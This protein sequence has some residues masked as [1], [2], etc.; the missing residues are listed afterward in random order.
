MLRLNCC[1]AV[2]K[3]NWQFNSIN[4]RD[5][6]VVEADEWWFAAEIHFVALQVHFIVSATI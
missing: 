5:W 6:G 4:D 1:G 3:T 2:P